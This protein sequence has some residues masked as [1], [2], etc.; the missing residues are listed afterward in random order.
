MHMLYFSFSSP[1]ICSRFVTPSSMI[2]KAQVL[3]S[4]DAYVKIKSEGLTVEKL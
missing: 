3:G 4:D 1:V 2:L